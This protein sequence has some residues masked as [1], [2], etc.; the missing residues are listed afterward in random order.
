M[1]LQSQNPLFVVADM[2]RSKNFYK[3]VLGLEPVSDFGAN[4]VLEGGLALQTLDSWA[5]FLGKTPEEIAFGGNDS[6]VYFET[7][8]FDGFLR[9]L[10]ERPSVELVH[11]PLEHRW[12]QR[13]VRLYDPDRRGGGG[14]ERRVPPLPGQRP[15][16]G[17]HRP[18]DGCAGGICPGAIEKAIKTIP[19]R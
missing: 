16:R 12:G 5:G 6:E 13:V 2:E 17:G 7:G 8:D 19:R 11:A 10:F 18:P 1:K 4:V 3:T 9:Q 14:H 15:G